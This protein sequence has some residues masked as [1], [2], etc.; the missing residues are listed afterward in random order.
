MSSSGWSRQGRLILLG[1]LSFWLLDVLLHALERDNFFGFDVW[2]LTVTMPLLFLAAHFLAKRL[3]G[4]SVLVA[5][6]MLLGAWVLGGI[7]M[8]LGASVSGLAIGSFW[9]ILSILLVSVLPPATFMM[10]GYDGSLFALVLVTGI[11]AV[12]WIVEAARR[13][14]RPA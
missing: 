2:L 8:L 7:F 4:R 14:A 12:L 13:P 11:A 5:P 9:D 3:Y 6:W 1:A 10:S